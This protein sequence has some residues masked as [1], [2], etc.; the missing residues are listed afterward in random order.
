MRIAVASGKGGTGKTTVTAS[1]AAVWNTP[2]ILADLDVEEPNL[3]LFLPFRQRETEPVHLRTPNV[4]ES[5]CTL[6]GACAELCRFKAIALLG[7]IIVAFPEMCHGCGG[8]FRICPVEAISAQLREVGVVETGR[9]H[10]SHESD[11]RFVMGRSRI[12]E[13]M[14]PPLI[15]ATRKRVDSMA[16]SRSDVLMDAPPGV[17]CPAVTAVRDTDLVLLV[18]EPTPF[19]FHDFRLA[20]QAFARL[21]ASLAVV[22]NKAGLDDAPLET[23]CREHDLPILARIPY[24]D[25]IARCYSTGDLIINA[26]PEIRLEFEALRDALRARIPVE[27][28]IHA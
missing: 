9:V 11:I 4:D 16:D 25:Q 21:G 19:G 20:A 24:D 1:L 7:P 6:C 23:Y 18:A 8:C 15:R 2:L 3:H 17:S 14:S 12:G 5:I 27:E 26:R 28:R 22:V 13:A 10:L